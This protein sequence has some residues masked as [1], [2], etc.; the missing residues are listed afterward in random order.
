[1][2]L[3]DCDALDYDPILLGQGTDDTTG[4]ALVLASDDLHLISFFDV[5]I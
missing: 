4:L 5:H 2:A 1:M 3:G